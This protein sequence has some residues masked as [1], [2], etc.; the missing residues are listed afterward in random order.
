MPFAS[1]I[2]HLEKLSPT[3]G[4]RQAV[5]KP[6][7]LQHVTPTSWTGAAAAPPVEAFYATRSRVVKVGFSFRIRTLRLTVRPSSATC[8]KPPTHFYRRYSTRTMYA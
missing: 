7:R 6:P 4:K 5:E 2:S 3:D 1:A 8:Q